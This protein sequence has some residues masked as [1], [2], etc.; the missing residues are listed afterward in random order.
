MSHFHGPDG[1]APHA[2]VE[3]NDRIRHLMTKPATTARAEEYRELLSL[4][5]EA[6]RDE[7]ERAA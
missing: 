6:S 3:V 7:F 1:Q 5:A 2:L 4:W